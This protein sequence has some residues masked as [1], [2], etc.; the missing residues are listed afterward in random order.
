MNKT[1]LLS[2]A[3]VILFIVGWCLFLRG[4]DS[5]YEVSS[6][7]ERP[8]SGSRLS[9]LDKQTQNK[10]DVNAPVDLGH[11]IN[12]WHLKASGVFPIDYSVSFSN[13]LSI[14]ISPLSSSKP[15][16][17]TKFA[18]KILNLMKPE[19]CGEF[20]GVELCA[21]NGEF[22]SNVHPQQGGIF[23]NNKGRLTPSFNS[24][25][26]DIGEPVMPENID[27][28]LM[29]LISGLKE[30]LATPKS[31]RLLQQEGL[32]FRIRFNLPSENGYVD[33]KSSWIEIDSVG[34]DYLIEYLDSVE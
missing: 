31:R 34:K 4:H 23:Y 5:E 6:F 16:V 26:T 10:T 3:I 19:S 29:D 25:R 7:K 18:E 12:D 1:I 2:L 27:I 22:L 13:D 28:S 11:N 30:H 9:P 15:V 17:L 8:L 33:F 14:R 21:G 32:R 24:E 20:I